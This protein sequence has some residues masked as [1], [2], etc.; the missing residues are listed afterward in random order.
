MHIE[1]AD[2]VPVKNRKWGAVIIRILVG[3]ACLALV[4]ALG[5]RMLGWLD[6]KQ[7][8][9][10]VL[11]NAWNSVDSTGYSADLTDIGNGMK[12]DRI[13]AESLKNMMDDC[14]SA[15]NQPIIC[16][17]YR[18]RSAQQ[19]LYDDKIQRLVEEG[20]SAE[21]APGLAAMSVAM[22]GTSEHELGLAFDIV[23]YNYQVLDEAQKDTPTA[24]WLTDNCWRYGFILR[25]PNGK[26]DTT[27]ITYE[28]WHFRYVG[29]A[30]A[31]QI[32]QMGITLEEYVSMFYNEQATITYG[33]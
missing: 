9:E 20:V 18:S 25:Y 17:A 7:L 26:Q 1:D 15:G 30:A 8:E 19:E 4:A 32:S 33:D 21:A 29:R 23:D 3:I 11:V 12:A 14:A 16:S 27:G 13:C 24:Q 10:L 22:P 2:F 5:L 6:N 28:P 31:E